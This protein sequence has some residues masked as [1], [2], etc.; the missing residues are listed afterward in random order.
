MDICVD[1]GFVLPNQLIPKITTFKALG[2]LLTMMMYN[3]KL[4]SHHENRPIKLV[5]DLL[6]L[7]SRH[8]PLI[9]FF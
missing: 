5:L 6:F 3:K 1:Y 2:F 7:S 4:T 9:N 8:R